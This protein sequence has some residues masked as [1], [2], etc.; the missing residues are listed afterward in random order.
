MVF[1]CIIIIRVRL[2]KTKIKTAEG[3]MCYVIIYLSIQRTEL[4]SVST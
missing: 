1:L 3:S 2:V 4:F